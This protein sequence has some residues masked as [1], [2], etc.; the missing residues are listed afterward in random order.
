MTPDDP[1]LQR[2]ITDTL[3]EYLEAI[4]PDLPPHSFAFF[5]VITPD[6]TDYYYTKG[7]PRD[8]VIDVLRILANQL[9]RAQWPHR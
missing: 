5:A 9:E 7:L 2:L 8:S 3:R 1:D 6:G 4:E